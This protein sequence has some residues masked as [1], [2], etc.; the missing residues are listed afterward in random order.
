MR[1]FIYVCVFVRVCMMR[2]AAIPPGI[3]TAQRAKLDTRDGAV[4]RGGLRRRRDNA[5]ARGDFPVGRSDG[6]NTVKS[7]NGA[8]VYGT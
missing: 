6:Q 2:Y 8:T 1:H 5:C 4:G 7:L 3:Q